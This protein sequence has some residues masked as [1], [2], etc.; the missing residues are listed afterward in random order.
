MLG[1]QFRG[2]LARREELDFRHQNG[3]AVRCRRMSA[4]PIS[5]ARGHQREPHHAIHG[6]KYSVIRHHTKHTTPRK[7]AGS[8]AAG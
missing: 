5:P 3:T 1:A 6:R 7:I 4:S 8:A 2:E